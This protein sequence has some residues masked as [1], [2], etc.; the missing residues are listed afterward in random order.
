MMIYPIEKVDNIFC[1]RSEDKGE[2][3]WTNITFSIL[4][5]KKYT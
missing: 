1:E 4:N 3:N 5:V 2:I